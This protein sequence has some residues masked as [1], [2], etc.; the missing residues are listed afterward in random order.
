[1]S[2]I[3]IPAGALTAP[4]N[5]D[6]DAQP[7]G[8]YWFWPVLRFPLEFHLRPIRPDLVA[9]EDDQAAGVVWY[10]RRIYPPDVKGM[11]NPEAADFVDLVVPSVIIPEPDGTTPGQYPCG[12]LCRVSLEGEELCTAFRERGDGELARQHAAD[13]VVWAWQ[14]AASELKEGNALGG[15]LNG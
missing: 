5:A 7:R 6:R 14:F 15:G 10:V 2:D 8:R 4:D 11:V 9:F 13:F 3:V 12:A 1:M